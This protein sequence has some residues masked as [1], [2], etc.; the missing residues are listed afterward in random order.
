MNYIYEYP[1]ALVTV[2]A[3]IIDATNKQNLLLIERGNEPYKGMWAM[4]G[5]FIEM[6]EN[7]EQSVIREV[8]EETSLSGISFTQ[9]MAF[10][11]IGR[12]PRGRNIAVVFYGF[13]KNI[14]DAKAND[15][16]KSLKWFNINN[17]P[18]LAF[19]HEKIINSFLSQVTVYC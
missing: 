16:A 1:R 7:L 6:D 19:D 14:N 18:K 17:L 10:G 15:D 5:G 8:F 3:I 9:F 13:C 11:D 12:D 4:P 2:D